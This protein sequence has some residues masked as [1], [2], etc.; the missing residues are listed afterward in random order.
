M[1]GNRVQWTLLLGTALAMVVAPVPAF[2][3]AKDGGKDVAGKSKTPSAVPGSIRGDVSGTPG[4]TQPLGGTI[5]PKWT[6]IRGFWGDATPFWTNIRGFWGDTNPY[7][8]N[9]TAF[10]GNMSSSFDPTATQD[11]VTPSWTNIRGF[12]GD[13]GAS[14][15]NI[16]G[17]WTNIRGFGDAPEDYATLSSQLND[18]VTKSSLFWGDAVTARTG[19]SFAN[20]FANPL[21]AK[22]GIDLKDPSTL[23]NL[24]PDA[25]EHFFVDWYD[26][27]M[28][29]S[30]HDQVDHWMKEVNWTPSLTQMLGAGSDSVVGLLDFS[31]TGDEAMNVTK[32][33]GV[34]TFTNGHGSAVASLMVAPHDGKGVMGIAPRAAV[35]EYNPFDET[36][37]AGWAD[38]KAGV[39]Y[40][41]QNKASIVNM[42]LG[43]PGW[44][45]NQGWN[46]VFADKQVRDATKNVVFVIAAGNDG[47]TQTQDIKWSKDNPNIIVVGSVDPTGTISSFSNR[48]GDACLLDG[49]KCGP[50][51]KLMNRFIVAPGEFILT[52]DGQGGTMRVSGTSF[53]APLVSGTIALI[54]DR[55]PWLVKY[56]KETSDIILKSARDLGAPGTDPVYGVGELDV[57]A[58]LSPL[59]MNNVKFYQYDGKGNLAEQ[60]VKRLSDS[61]QQALW[62]ANSVYYYVYEKIGG[63]FRDFAVPLSSKLIG[64]SVLSAGGTQ[65]MFQ[66]YVTSRLTGWLSQTAKGGKGFTGDG[67]ALL[68][69]SGTDATVPNAYGLNVTMAIAPR[70]PLFGYRQPTSPYQTALKLADREGR[71]ALTVGNGD[72]AVALG[73][74]RGFGY[75]SD[76]DPTVGGANPLLGFASG[77]SFGEASLAVSDRLTVSTSLTARALR[78]DMRR[79]TLAEQVQFGGVD[80]YRSSAQQVSFDYR[81]ANGV[82][83]NASLTRLQESNALFGTQ[84]LDRQDFAGG[85][86]T[87][88]ATMG[89]DISV[90]PTFSVAASATLG[91]TGSNGGRGNFDVSRSGLMTSSFQVA[92]S[93]T[94]LLGKSDRLR[95]TLSQPM[96]LE[97]G[98]LD[99]TMVAV[100]DRQTGQLGAVTRSFDIAT[101]QRQFVA[102]M[103]Y[104][105]SVMNGAAQVNLFGRARLAGS[106]QPGAKTSGLPNFIA[107]AGFNL[108]F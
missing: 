99:Y 18:M 14:W 30:G 25:R 72:G 31:V 80:G 90:T 92:M 51:K 95:L 29:Y 87:D 91:R 52:S 79:A 21:F 71:F 13:L 98:S 38:I 28:A 24:E 4:T 57:A 7:E 2:A 11:S 101:E 100:V 61:K 5:E 3:G 15:T 62:E 6:N 108:G 82:T 76:Y 66:S 50:D 9:L 40:L 58:A 45:L 107:G 81:V 44:T 86:T 46:D 37:T 85:M 106:N 84:S 53:A 94:S 16:R 8:G 60:D 74:T 39:L 88:G 12:W 75:A 32:A 97:H 93:K 103:G 67:R 22:Y 33:A 77:G 26:G 35:V 49:D 96:H 59:E 20:G 36:A 65:E 1:M 64:Q 19:Q 34:S 68:G 17:F 73:A 54:Q 48:P 78:R 43:V 105:R 104:G 89:G 63:S 69:F 83:L 55:W 10:W 102:E 56:P 23:Q 70:R 47:V 27:L 42:S 41:S